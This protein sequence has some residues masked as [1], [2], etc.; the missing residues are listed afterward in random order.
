MDDWSGC[1]MLGSRL[2]ALRFQT[3]TM[4]TREPNVRS[5]GKGLTS[6]GLKIDDD[7]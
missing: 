6:S 2:A 1:F 5:A 7:L 4:L 3:S